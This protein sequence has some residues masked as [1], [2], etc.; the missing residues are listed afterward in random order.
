MNICI[1]SGGTRLRLP[2]P[3]NH[4]IYAD[5]HKLDYRLECGSNGRLKNPFYFK[6]DVIARLLPS[7]DWIFWIDDDAFFTNFSVDPGGVCRSQA[8]KTFLILADGR[9][10]PGDGWTRINSGV[11]LVRNCKEAR[12][13]LQKCLDTEI[14]TV[15][16]WWNEADHGMFTN[17]DQD[18]LLY[19]LLC[20]PVQD[21]FEIAPHL[22]LNARSYH[23]SK[24]ITEHF[25]CHF[26]GL[27]DKV[28]A[29]RQFSDRF[30]VGLTL[31]PK[32][33]LKEHGYERVV[34]DDF[35]LQPKRPFLE[36]VQR[37]LHR[38]LSPGK[39]A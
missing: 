14:A 22:D 25:I 19:H 38:L 4:K 37:R 23:Y 2:S 39:N 3:I 31:V 20:S 18:T 9:V 11:I 34:D 6:L 26:P 8:H 27:P 13:F 5:I 7:Y 33:L 21:F 28:R 15:R 35:I 1:V 24:E 30:G 12:T 32:T 29:I 16:S 17:S 10:R 36:R